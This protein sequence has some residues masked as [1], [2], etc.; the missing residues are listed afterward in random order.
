M[1]A[2]KLPVCTGWWEERRQADAPDW[3]LREYQE[4]MRT[5][6]PAMVARTIWGSSLQ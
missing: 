1:S 6:A 4:L 3:A 2:Q 5:H